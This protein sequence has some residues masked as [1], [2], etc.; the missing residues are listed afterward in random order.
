MRVA[1]EAGATSADHCTYLS[2]ED[3]AALA[4]S[5]TVATLL[6]ITEFSTRTAYADGRRLLD[7]GALVALASNCNP[8]SGYSSS[9]HLAIALAV[10][11]CGLT[12]SEALFAATAGGAAALARD[13]VGA[14]RVGMRGDVVLLDAPDPVHLAYRPGMDLV[15][16]VWC[17]GERVR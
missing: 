11:E 14:L 7:A 17:A 12:P 6:P 10:R 8:G 16:G 3:V 4:D 1:V 15:A 9:M 13:D 2:S 5:R